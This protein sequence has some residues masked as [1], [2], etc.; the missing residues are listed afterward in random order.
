MISLN[1][2]KNCSSSSASSS[3][4]FLSKNALAPSPMTAAAAIPEAAGITE[5]PVDL[6]VV[7]LA[8]AIGADEVEIIDADIYLEEYEE[9]LNE[10]EEAY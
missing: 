2:Y 10:E 1:D 5:L 4:F 7:V 9:G 3:C 8:L 6:A